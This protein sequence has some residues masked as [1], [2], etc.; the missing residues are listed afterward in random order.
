MPVKKRI[1]LDLETTGLDPEY[2]EI[3]QLSIIDA[4]TG[5]TI[6]NTLIEPEYCVSWPEA[7]NVHG[8]TPKMVKGKPKLSDLHDQLIALMDN[9]KTVIGYNTFFDLGFLEEGLGQHFCVDVVDVM[10]DFAKEY[11]EW[12]DYYGNWKWQKLVTAASYYHYDWGTDTAH[13][14]LA[15]CRATLYV[16]NKMHVND[17]EEDD[18]WD[19][20]WDDWDDD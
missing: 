2:D 20:D 9:T 12:S 8:I 17:N 1:V 16:Y 14:S 18:D 6:I 4:R 5:D 7:E 11:G 3:L 13:D 10:K 15:D 19:D